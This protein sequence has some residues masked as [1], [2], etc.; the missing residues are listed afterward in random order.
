MIW[1]VLIIHNLILGLFSILTFT[2]FMSFRGWGY[3]SKVCC[4]VIT[5]LKSWWIISRGATTFLLMLL[6]L[7][8]LRWSIINIWVLTFSLLYKW[9]CLGKERTRGV[10]NNINSHK[11]RNTT[12][13][14]TNKTSTCIGG[15][16]FHTSSFHMQKEGRVKKYA[17][18]VSYN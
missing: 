8:A 5:I 3:G 15:I 14:L 4:A 16:R 17:L 6:R 18:L 10:Y 9:V 11:Q 7:Y 1:L 2:S 12:Y 13:K